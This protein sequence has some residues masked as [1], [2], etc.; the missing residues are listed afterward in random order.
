VS[1]PRPGERLFKTWA[2]LAGCATGQSAPHTVFAPTDA[3]FK[4]ITVPTDPAVVRDVLL[5]HMP[6]ARTDQHPLDG[7][8]PIKDTAGVAPMLDALTDPPAEGGAKKD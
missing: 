6:D 5:L 2:S 4:A 8:P 3:A 1:S 7:G